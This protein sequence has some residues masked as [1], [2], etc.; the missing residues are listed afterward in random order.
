MLELFTCRNC[1]T[2]YGRAYSDNVDNPDFLW[3]EAGG[4]FRTLAGHVGELSP[5]DLLLEQP[6]FKD[7][8]EPAEYDLLT[9]RLNP[10]KL[11]DRNRQVYLRKDRTQPVGPDE[12]VDGNRGEFR[13]CAVCG[14]Q[15]G[16]GPNLGTG[17]P[18]ERRPA[19]PGAHRQ[20]DPGPAP[21]PHAGDAV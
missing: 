12:P 2:A 18:D 17:S 9:G 10:H 13:P 6:V 5:L 21:E 7:V 15:A 16:Y 20:A 8:V 19:V 1:G 11:G 3:A 4:A 14:E